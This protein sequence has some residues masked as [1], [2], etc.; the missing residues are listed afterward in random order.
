MAWVLRTSL[1]S[2][3]LCFLSGNGGM[4]CWRRVCGEMFWELGTGIGGIWTQ[5]WYI[6]SNLCGGRICV[7]SFI[8]TL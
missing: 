5:L 4:G 8:N 6:E 2:M 7:K 3:M 1:I